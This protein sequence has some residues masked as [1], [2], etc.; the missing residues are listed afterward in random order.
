MQV[1]KEEKALVIYGEDFDIESTLECGQIFSFQKDDCGRYIVTS[2][3]KWAR[4]TYGDGMT[5]IETKDVDY[6]YNFFDLDT[7]YVSIRERLCEIYPQF[8]RFLSCGK[9]I[10]ILRQD[11]VQTIL[12][13]IVSANNNIKRIK[14]ILFSLSQRYGE[15][16][17]RGV[18]SFPSLDSLSS[19]TE[20]D[21]VS[22]GM[23]YRAPY[24]VETIS[25]LKSLD[26]DYLSSLST[27][28]LRKVLLNLKGVGPKVAD[29]IL[30]FGFSRTDVFPVDTWIRKSY[31]LFCEDKRSDKEIAA[32]F[33]S[34]FG[35]YSGYAQQYIFNYM[36]NTY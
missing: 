25:R 24:M 23:G 35:K 8:D 34:L 12:S 1:T 3:D 14:K 6:F 29:C 22:L 26:M 5:R 16:I 20:A 21:F 4:I 17:E 13:F 27:V 9:N 15:E 28:E 10:R 2:L 33:V 30:F 18:F 19:V 32:Y 31:S 11:K 36:I 7:D